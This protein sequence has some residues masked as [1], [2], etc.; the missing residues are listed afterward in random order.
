MVVEKLDALYAVA[1]ALTVDDIATLTVPTLVILEDD[2]EVQLDHAVAMNRALP[3][4][5]P[6]VL[7]RRLTDSWMRNRC[8]SRS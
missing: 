1:P 3:D 4:G 2:D 6:A 5:E 7:P 8:C